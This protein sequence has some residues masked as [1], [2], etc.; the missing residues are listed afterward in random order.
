[1]STTV[2][3]LGARLTHTGLAVERSGAVRGELEFDAKVAS[4]VTVTWDPATPRRCVAVS[5]GTARARRH[6]RAPDVDRTPWLRLAAV[7]M[8]DHRLYLPLNRALLDA[9][10]AA[11]EVGAAADAGPGEPARPPRRPSPGRARSAARE[12]VGT[13]TGGQDRP[14]PT[15][16]LAASLSGSPR[17]HGPRRRSG[18]LRRCAGP[19]D[20]G[21]DR[22]AGGMPVTCTRARR[23]SVAPS[24]RRVRHRSTLRSVPARLLRLGPAADSAEIEATRRTW[25]IAGPARA[26]TGVRAHFRSGSASRTSRCG[27]ST[28][29]P[30]RSTATAFSEFC[31]GW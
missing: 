30:D 8:L 23:V 19:G 24:R 4:G 21:L 6:Q 9:E 7:T 10:I 28:A 15:R 17:V 2:S 22:M 25:R 11:A 31:T 3:A 29:V 18:R 16:A 13:S 20:R 27:W 5:V 12:L 1:M 14:A 26:R